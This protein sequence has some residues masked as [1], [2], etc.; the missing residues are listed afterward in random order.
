MIGVLAQ[1]SMNPDTS[2]LPGGA[3][4]QNIANGIGGWAIVLALV[5]VW[6]DLR[7][8]AFAALVVGLT[9]MIN[10]LARPILGY[11]Q[12]TE[13]AEI[14][15]VGSKPL[16]GVS[17][18]SLL[19]APAEEQNK[20]A[21]V[22]AKLRDR[23]IFSHWNGRVSAATGRFRLDHTGKLYDVLEDPGQITNI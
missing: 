20:S 13:L 22:P 8:R 19:V 14:P 11:W 6:F 5:S 18:K 17:L 21:P 23:L 3:V 15:N 7:S 10:T 16:D 1:V 12:L 9:G 2:Q 4:L